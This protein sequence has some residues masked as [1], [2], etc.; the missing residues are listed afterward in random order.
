MRLPNGFGS[1]YKLKGKR[2]KPWVARRTVGYN[3]RG[4]QVY[5]YIGY[6]TTRAEAL[7]ALATKA[8]PEKRSGAPTLAEVWELYDERVLCARSDHYRKM[9]E[10]MW[11]NH[12]AG[13]GPVRVDELS[14]QVIQDYVRTIPAALQAPVMTE[15]HAILKEAVLRGILPAGSEN[16]TRYVEKEKHT[17]RA[18]VPFSEAQIEELWAHADQLVP[19]LALLLIYTGLR[20]GE[21]AA[22][23]PEDITEEFLTIRKSKTAAGIRTVPIHHRIR[24]FAAELARWCGE[25]TVHNIRY[26]W[27]LYFEPLGVTEM[28]HACRHT[29]I[30]RLV[31]AGVDPRL[32]RA[33]VGHAGGTVTDDVYTHVRPEVLLEAI[34]R[35]P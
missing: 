33:I 27:K 16:V 1:V 3:D 29:C 2:R 13:L 26:H 17:P 9:Y 10:S 5:E 20:V 15:L 28:P 30:T 24:P 34:E 32:V 31:E 35:V 6:Y 8:E 4:Q 7:E 22:L 19:R 21:L 23:A 14:L 25:R 18:K 11:R 12:L